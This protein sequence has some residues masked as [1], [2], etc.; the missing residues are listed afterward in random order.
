MATTW[1]ELAVVLDAEN[2]QPS[3][4]A[5]GSFLG[6]VGRQAPESDSRDY[7]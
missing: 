4:D 2:A 3:V 5:S 1:I 6:S 7:G